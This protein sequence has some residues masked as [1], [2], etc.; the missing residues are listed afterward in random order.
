L[1][2][3]I[4]AHFQIPAKAKGPSITFVLIIVIGTSQNTLRNED[5]TGNA[6]V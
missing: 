5:H 3:S 2:S 4:I 6:A 1:N